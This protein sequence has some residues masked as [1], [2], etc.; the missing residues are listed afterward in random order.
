MKMVT[1]NSFS[2]KLRVNTPCIS[3]VFQ[4]AFQGLIPQ[5]EQAGKDHSAIGEALPW[6]TEMKTILGKPEMLQAEENFENKPYS[7]KI[8]EVFHPEQDES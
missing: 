5:H 1:A 3:N 7:Q 4:S 8:R 6:K 2:V